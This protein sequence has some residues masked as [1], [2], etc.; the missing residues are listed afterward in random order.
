MGYSIGEVA[1]K[2]GVAPSALRY[3]E[4]EGLLPAVERTTGGRRLF[5]QKDVEAC[6]V[7]ECLKR[8][9]LS[10]KDI[11]DFM[12]MVRQGD[13]TLQG[14]LTLFQGRKESL[15]REI[16]ELHNV[17]AVLDFKTWYYQ[18]AVS[19]GTESAVQNLPPEQ[20]PGQH[21]AAHAF[22]ADDLH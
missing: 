10:I 1:Q 15:E 3:Y 22:L 7:I 16:K 17:L 19:A 18:Q 6:R 12:D 21:R 8:S 14:R 5:S 9:G 11:K 2:L 4:A 13:A 20:I